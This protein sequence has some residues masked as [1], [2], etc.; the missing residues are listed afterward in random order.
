M[1]VAKESHEEYNMGR[2]LSP[3]CKLCRR[4]GQKLFLKG[5]RCH[6]QKCALV[7]RNYA[8]GI[9]G[10]RQGAGGANLTGYGVQ[11][12]A[13]QKAK[14]MYT[15]SETQFI[16]YYKKAMNRKGNTEDELFKLLEYR[17]D[18]VVY[19]LGLAG[20]RK[21]ARQLVNHGHFQVNGKKVNVPSYQVRIKD[22]ISLRDKSLKMVKIQA[23]L[24][25]KKVKKEELVDWLV[26][27]EKEN[28]GKIVGEPSVATQKPAF[29]MKA[30]LEFYS[31]L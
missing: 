19:R 16:N 18:N 21:E 25:A 30:I 10:P 27:D 17:L 6:S 4:E 31:K 29:D 7:R 23:L 24:E 9:H 11:L 13:K 2:L 3:Q 8:P 26:F 14:R 28:K 22:E 15:L 12:R 1:V 5:E 20:S